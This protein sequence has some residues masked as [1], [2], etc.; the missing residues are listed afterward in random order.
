MDKQLDDPRSCPCT[1]GCMETTFFIP[2]IAD[3]TEAHM[4]YRFSFADPAID[5]TLRGMGQRFD[6]TIGDLLQFS[7]QTNGAVQPLGDVVEDQTGWTIVLD[8]PGVRPDAVDVFTEGRLLTVQAART[9]EQFKQGARRITQ[10]RTTGNYARQFRLPRSADVESIAAHAEHGVL[11]LRISKL[12]PVQP[13]RVQV[14]V[15]SGSDAADR[16]VESDA[17]GNNAEQEALT[18]A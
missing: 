12:A 16:M 9:T 5:A 17:N 4:T 11:T 8:M 6:Q 1:H 13:R 15:A 3:E 7:T 14:N 10:E 18:G 2:S